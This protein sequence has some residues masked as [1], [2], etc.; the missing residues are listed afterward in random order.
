MQAKRALDGN[1]SNNSHIH[2][3]RGTG[4]EAGHPVCRHRHH[5]RPDQPL[6]STSTC[7][8]KYMY[9]GRAEFAITTTSPRARFVH[10]ARSQGLMG[11]VREEQENISRSS[12]LK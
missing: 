7:H 4:H 2:T 1:H 10:V 5:R 3:Q 11:K 9:H 8:S 6:C 12:S